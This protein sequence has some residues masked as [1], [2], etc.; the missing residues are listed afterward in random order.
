MDAVRKM[1]KSEGMKGGLRTRRLR[2]EETLTAF[3]FVTYPFFV[4][5]FPHNVIFL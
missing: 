3:K 5:V 4:G 2:P 1:G